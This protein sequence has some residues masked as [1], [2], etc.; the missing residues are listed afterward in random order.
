MTFTFV[1]AA[2]VAVELSPTSWADFDAG[3]VK[4]AADLLSIQQVD[5]EDTAMR[6]LLFVSAVA[7]IVPGPRGGCDIRL[8]RGLAWEL[9]CASELVALDG[10][11]GE[12]IAT[13]ITLEA[14]CRFTLTADG[15]GPIH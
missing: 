6:V 7:C 14:Q 8:L 3:M 15:L 12:K 2:R 13:G 1:D 5:K 10:E 4:Q 9:D 11:I